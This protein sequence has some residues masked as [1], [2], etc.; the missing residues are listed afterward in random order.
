M[1]SQDYQQRLFMAAK[2]AQASSIPSWNSV[3]FQALMNQESSPPLT[4]YL[5]PATA[6][7]NQ[8]Q[9]F[10]PNSPTFVPSPTNGSAMHAGMSTQ[11]VN[12]MQ[13]AAVQGLQATGSPLANTMPQQVQSFFGHAFEQTQQF[14]QHQ[15][16]I[17][18]ATQLLAQANVS[19]LDDG[20]GMSPRPVPQMMRH[21]ESSVGHAVGMVPGAMGAQPG[22]PASYAGAAAAA[23]VGPGMMQSPPVM[24][25]GQQAA[26]VNPPP[27]ISGSLGGSFQF[28]IE[29]TSSPEYDG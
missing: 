2:L 25:G 17:N 29:S 1:Q 3:L 9:M 15:M 10:F 27:Y 22:A 20:S 28:N 18:A 13:P 19:G 8:D 21:P 12:V 23:Q 7:G 11:G 6:S 14:Q 26:T 4:P 5:S 16:T 24:Y